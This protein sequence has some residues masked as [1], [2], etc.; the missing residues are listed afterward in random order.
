MP[1]LNI[2]TE[3]REVARL[4]CERGVISS[5]GYASELARGE[6]LPSYKLAMEIEAKTGIPLRH[7]RDLKLA[8][9]AQPA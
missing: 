3:P 9:E 2:P 7:W 4:L 5:T 1:K 6:R 8:R